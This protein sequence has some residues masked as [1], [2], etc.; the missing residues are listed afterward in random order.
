MVE[1]VA[2]A[3][4]Q[5]LMKVGSAV[6]NGAGFISAPAMGIRLEPMAT[7]V[8]LCTLS[9]RPK[10][11]KLYINA[12]GISYD[13]PGNKSKFTRRLTFASRDDLPVICS[14]IEQFTISYNSK[15]QHI[16]IICN[17][18]IQGLKELST[19]YD[20]DESGMTIVHCLQLYQEK[21]KTFL[22]PKDDFFEKESIREVKETL[23]LG[24]GLGSNSVG[25]GSTSSSSPIPGSPIMKAT[26][27][28]KKKKHR[29]N[30]STTTGSAGSAS[31]ASVGGI[32]GQ[33]LGSP[34]LLG[35]SPPVGSGI[36]AL[37]LLPPPLA[38]TLASTT[39]SAV[40]LSLYQNEH[41]D[42]NKFVKWPV[43]SIQIVLLILQKLA[44]LAAPIP[45]DSGGYE[46]RSRKQQVLIDEWLRAID[47]VIP[48]SND[49]S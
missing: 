48:I 26:E 19:C 16:R 49:E 8:S 6:L 28:R 27:E 39:S 45:I 5:V 12:S 11:T 15:H 21:I 9:Y 30:T 17:G 47:I 22:E 41:K 43:E 34:L 2:S 20:K 35:S 1:H 23:G 29:N 33:G 18:A 10:G 46:P 7:L 4:I 40:A 38:S 36:P 25:A 14:A 37:S 31:S 44:T 32:D 13:E 24:L 3:G 42:S